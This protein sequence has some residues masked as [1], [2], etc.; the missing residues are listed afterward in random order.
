MVI[1]IRKA[2]KKDLKEIGKLMKEELSKPPFNERDN[3]KNILKS[4][5]FYYKTARIYLN[6]ENKIKI[7][8]LVFQTEQWWE[9]PVIIIQDLVV[10]QKFQNQNIG[11]SFMKFLE[12]YAV[13]KNAKRI[14][15]ETNKKSSA[16][17]FYKKL[18]YKVNKD[19]ISMS[20]R[21]K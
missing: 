17:R 2:V 13:N 19:R 1:K 12:K 18:G 21:L 15:F 11:K 7:G 14:Y 5:N 8:I 10:K 20:K 16:I 6:E 9:G 3:I 4:L